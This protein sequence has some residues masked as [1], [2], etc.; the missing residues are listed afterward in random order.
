MIGLLHPG[1][2]SL[3]DW[4]WL[5]SYIIALVILPLGLVG[6][7]IYKVIASHSSDE[8]DHQDSNTI[9]FH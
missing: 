8:N 5:F 2:F 4:L 3:S 6:F 9:T 1:D 7:I